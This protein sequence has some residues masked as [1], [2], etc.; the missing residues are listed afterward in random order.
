MRRAILMSLIILLC[1]PLT[2]A[3]N[4]SVDTEESST[5][6][7]S[8]NYTVEDGA[9]WTISGHYE[10]EDGTTIVVE[11]GGAMVVTGS[12][13]STSDPHLEMTES[14]SIVVPVGYL[15]NLVQ[16]EFISP[17]N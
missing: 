5:G 14:S 10:V 16:C 2:A 6:T 1:Q 7:L 13:N 3:T 8:G 15:G 4:I 17:V 11:E 9:T 12:M